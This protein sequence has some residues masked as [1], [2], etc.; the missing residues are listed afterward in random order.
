M[1]LLVANG[2]RSRKIV[3]WSKELPDDSFFVYI[4][5]FHNDENVQFPCSNQ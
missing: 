3:V 2:S 4:D 5:I 1:P